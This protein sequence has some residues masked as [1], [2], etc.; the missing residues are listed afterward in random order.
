MVFFVYILESQSTGRHYIGQTDNIARRLEEHN[1]PE[2]KLSKYTSK[3]GGPWKL[4]Y[5]E[6]HPSRPAAVKREHWLKSRS[7]R[8]WVESKFG[9]A[10]PSILP[11]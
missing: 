1:D 3:Q 8:R 2:H 9:R 10:S 11:D 7:G 6:E 5:T 4:I